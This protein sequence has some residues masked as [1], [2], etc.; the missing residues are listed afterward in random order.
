MNRQHC[1]HHNRNATL[2]QSMESE[3]EIIKRTCL[4]D[5]QY[6][7]DGLDR[8]AQSRLVQNPCQ[9]LG[10]HATSKVLYTRTSQQRGK[11]FLLS[12]RLSACQTY[13]NKTQNPS[14]II[15]RIYLTCLS[16]D[17]LNMLQ[18]IDIFLVRVPRIWWFETYWQWH[19]L[20]I[21]KEITVFASSP[22]KT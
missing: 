6:R 18:N 8:S 4:H 1:K 12:N 7:V 15:L 19:E 11:T 5:N 9:H 17:L 21:L 14:D 10:K 3:S 2:N 20:S 16:F 13:A 22:S